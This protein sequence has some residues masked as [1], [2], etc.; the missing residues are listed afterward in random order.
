[1]QVIV[2]A[3]GPD[4]AFRGKWGWPRNLLEIGGSN[5]L[6]MSLGYVAR[7]HT[8]DQ[9]LLVLQREEC[10]EFLTDRVARLTVPSVEIVLADGKTNGA[11]CS[12]LL[13]SDRLCDDDELLLI[14]VDQWCSVELD[15]IVKEL[16][17]S[18]ADAGVATFDSRH[19][20]WSFVEVDDDGTV[21]SCAEK[22]PVSSRATAG[23]YWFKTAGNF[24]S[25]ACN[26]IDGG[27]LTDGNFFVAPC[28]NYE[29]LADRRV[30]EHRLPSGSYLSLHTVEDVLDNRER[31]L[32]F[33]NVW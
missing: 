19:P 27:N 26:S 11:L 25:S 18:G 8:V 24:V 2:L 5:I 4:D 3:A 32:S 22:N 16:R 1:M 23:M 20:R 21:L 6:E 31:I 15:E 30:K 7:S 29:L 17:A 14:N 9:I 12:A 28:M 33:V 13:A 10:E